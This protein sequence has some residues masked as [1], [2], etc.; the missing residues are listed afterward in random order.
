MTVK[1]HRK[2]IALGALLAI[3]TV[4][5]AVFKDIPTNFL[6]LLQFGF[7]TFVAGNAWERGTDA[8]CVTQGPPSAEVESDTPLPPAPVDLSPLHERLD[9]LAEHDAANSEAVATVQKTLSFIITKTGL[10]KAPPQAT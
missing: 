1:G 6:S 2:L 9:T 4:M 5:V 7:G 8:Y 10:D 3:G